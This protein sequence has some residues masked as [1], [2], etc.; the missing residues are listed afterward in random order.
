MLVE[1]RAVEARQA[2][3]IGREMRRHPVEQQADVVGMQRIDEAGEG[4]GR[5]EARGRREQAERLVTPRTAERMLGDGQQLDM[6]E[7]ELDDVGDQPLD[8]EIPQR[9]ARLAGA[10]SHEPIWTS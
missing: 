4:L 8:G 5:T 6:R 10:C 3:R 1:R 7:A 9:A 2:V